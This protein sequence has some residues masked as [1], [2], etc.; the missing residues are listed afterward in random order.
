MPNYNQKK[1]A[2]VRDGYFPKYTDRNG[3][4]LEYHMPA[5]Q[6]KDILGARQGEDK[7]M[8][9]QD[10]LC[11]YMNMEGGLLGYVTRVVIV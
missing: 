8:D 5:A 1:R 2:K 10:Y 7:K 9:P 4:Y 3:P 11:W 6:A